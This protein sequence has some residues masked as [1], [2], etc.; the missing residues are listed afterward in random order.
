MLT[1]GLLLLIQYK[2]QLFTWLQD[3]TVSMFLL[4][5]VSCSCVF[6]E[7]LITILLSSTTS[8]LKPPSSTGTL[9]TLFGFS[10]LLLFI[11]GEVFY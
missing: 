6:Y 7:L 8:A 5:R 10:F 11:T 4:V 9:L 1:L 2:A 3:F